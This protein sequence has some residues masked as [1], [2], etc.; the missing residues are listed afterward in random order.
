MSER[1]KK[2]K[3]SVYFKKSINKW[4]AK[5]TINNKEK[6]IGSYVTQKEA[7]VALNGFLKNI[8]NVTDDYKLYTFKDVYLKSMDSKT[9]LYDKGKAVKK[10]KSCAEQYK[11]SFMVFK[12][13]HDKLFLNIKFEEIIRIIEDANK[14]VASNKKIKLM[15]SIMYQYAEDMDMIDKNPVKN[16]HNWIDIV[17][18][19]YNENNKHRSLSL[20]EINKIFAYPEYTYMVDIIKF[21]LYTGVRIGEF[22][23]LKK[24]DIFISREK[25]YI[26]LPANYTKTRK[27][28][29]IP[30][31]D[32]ID[33]IISN[34]LKNN[35]TIY[36][37]ETP[38]KLQFTDS[39]FRNT[40]FFPFI[41]EVGIVNFIPHDTRYTFK[42]RSSTLRM[43]NTYV[44]YFM[45]HIDKNNMSILYNEAIN[46]AKNK[47]PDCLETLSKNINELNYKN[48][49]LR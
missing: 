35:K 30:I 5:V 27:S 7:Q 45:G 8:N 43:D 18:E 48:N 12:S 44:E 3:G 25:K 41:K 10:T 11:Y 4:V 23:Q 46:G 47:N 39:N 32:D 24:S 6:R 49:D 29:I 31:H 26:L 20:E 42:T 33:D 34:N 2:G 38:S 9:K 1:R 21:L 22:Y 15:L 28:R 40:Y 14:G 13:I 36:L 17:T 19:Q 37:F 16:K